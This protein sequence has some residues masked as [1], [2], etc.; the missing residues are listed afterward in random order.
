MV[1]FVKN[2]RTSHGF[3]FIVFFCWWI[4]LSCF[5][6]IMISYT[7]CKS[8]QRCS[9][10]VCGGKKEQVWWWWF[11]PTQKHMDTLEKDPIKNIKKR[12]NVFSVQLT[13]WIID[14]TSFSNSFTEK[15]MKS[16]FFSPIIFLSVAGKE[17]ISIPH[18][19]V[20]KGKIY[21]I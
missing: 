15:A 1:K 5:Q 21:A 2:R 19:N 16:M 11:Y 10:T 7:L 14:F 18:P 13:A 3:F 17:W 6:Y 12:F 20:V 4:V 8:T 9:F